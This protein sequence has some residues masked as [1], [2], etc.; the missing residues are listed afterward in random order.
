VVLSSGYPGVG[1]TP[2]RSSRKKDSPDTP[3]ISIKIKASGPVAKT[4]APVAKQVAKSMATKVT[5]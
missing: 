2:K 5:K 3:K 1:A 4:V